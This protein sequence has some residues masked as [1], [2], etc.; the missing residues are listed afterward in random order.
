MARVD[1]V[2]AS[3]WQDGSLHRTWSRVGVQRKTT[4]KLTPHDTFFVTPDQRDAKLT[5]T[6]NAFQRRPAL[7]VAHVTRFR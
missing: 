3:F 4:R 2:I 7:I 6:F 5:D 1:T